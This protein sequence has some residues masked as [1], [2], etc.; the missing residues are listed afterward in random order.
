MSILDTVIGGA[1]SLLSGIGSLVYGGQQVK[2]GEAELALTKKIS[3]ENLNLQKD[4]LAWQKDMQGQAWA[5]EDN[6]TQRRV[7]DLRKAGLSPV[8]AAG[9]A[10][11]SSGPIRIDTP[12]REAPSFRGL[13]EGVS[14]Q[15]ARMLTMQ[16]VA[17]SF[18][19]TQLIGQQLEKVR[20]E[21]RGQN[22][23]NEE[24]EWNLKFWQD[25]HAPTQPGHILGNLMPLATNLMGDWNQGIAQGTQ[26]AKE[27]IA[28]IESF[29]KSLPA[30]LM[31]PVINWFKQTLK[32]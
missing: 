18:L 10:A 16:S 5:R 21:T 9:S 14:S 26:D 3:D 4:T 29:I 6:A 31:G 27:I 19:E 15:A 25:K 12:Q 20:S 1:G 28:K 30:N 23:S 22:I 17:K 7:A 32:K 24:K 2:L 11:Q 8:L 13:Q